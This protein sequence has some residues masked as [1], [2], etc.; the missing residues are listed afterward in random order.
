MR[1]DLS[2]LRRHLGV[3]QCRWRAVPCVS[4]K[5]LIGV[6]TRKL[7]V[8]IR[9]VLVAAWIIAANGMAGRRIAV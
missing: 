2:L 6:W 9:A 4:T 1:V 3:I 7:C 5:G 8:Q